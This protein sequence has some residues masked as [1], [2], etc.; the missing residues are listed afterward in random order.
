[1]A[2]KPS[3]PVKAPSA[4]MSIV[5]VHGPELFLHAEYTKRLVDSLDMRRGPGAIR[6][7]V[8]TGQLQAVVPAGTEASAWPK[9][10]EF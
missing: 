8:T 10:R 4:E 1:M 6:C 2:R 5:I 7:V 3:T 9:R